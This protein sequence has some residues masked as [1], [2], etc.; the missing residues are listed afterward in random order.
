MEGYEICQSKQ[1]T[2]K[3]PASKKPPNYKDNMSSVWQYF[4]W[5]QSKEKWKLK[6]LMTDMGMDGTNNCLW[7]FH[8]SATVVFWVCD[9]YSFKVSLH[10]SGSYIHVNFYFFF[11]FLNKLKGLALIFVLSMIPF[12]WSMWKKI[13]LQTLLYTFLIILWWYLMYKNR[14]KKKHMCLWLIQLEI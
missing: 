2:S 4:W 11:L 7:S 9:F 13:I 14:T 8:G 10:C 6:Q 12:R 3:A 5:K 1:S